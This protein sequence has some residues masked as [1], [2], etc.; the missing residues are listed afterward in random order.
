MF[1]I[2]KEK[3]AAFLLK[4]KLKNRQIDEQSF[5]TAFKKSFAF[6]VLMPEN[7]RDFR[8]SF[9]LLEF[10]EHNGKNLTIL[11]RDYRI[12][13]LPAKFRNKAIEFGINDL[14]K[15]DLPSH[16]LL[17]KLDSMRFDAVVDLNR[18]NIIF[19]SYVANVVKAKLRIGFTKEG[20]DIYYNLQ[21]A[22][23]EPDSEISYNN[24]LNCIKMF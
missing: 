10:F 13:L 15:F 5:S 16:K 11:T 17:Q 3:T 24:F 9:S 1:D 23:K 14:N 19:Y 8:A 4:K 6:L 21:I 12:S 7:E 18:E 20:S 22:N 2:I